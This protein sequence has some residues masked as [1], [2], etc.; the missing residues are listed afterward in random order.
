MQLL[1]L[2]PLILPPL[3]PLECCSQEGKYDDGHQ[4]RGSNPNDILGR[5]EEEGETV[6]GINGC[7][8][9]DDEIGVGDD[10]LEAMLVV[11]LMDGISHGKGINEVVCPAKTKDAAWL[12]QSS[13]TG[14]REL[15]T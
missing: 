4:H 1:P 9:R 12:R 2:L 3:P 10:S 7:G 5:I 15:G 13:I 6:I 14:L 8:G 11:L